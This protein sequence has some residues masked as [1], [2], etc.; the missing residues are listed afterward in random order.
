MREQLPVERREVSFRITAALTP[1]R[2]PLNGPRLPAV[3]IVG[4]STLHLSCG[5][6]SR[7]HRKRPHV[8]KQQQNW[9]NASSFAVTC[10]TKPSSVA[11]PSQSVNLHRATARHA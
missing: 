5:P 6:V 4:G 10:N 8:W 7:A 11:V 1:E 3:A 2:R 9:N